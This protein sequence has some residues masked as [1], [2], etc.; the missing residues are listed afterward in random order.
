[1]SIREYS[2]VGAATTLYGVIPCPIS[3][4][5]KTEVDLSWILHRSM[6]AE[7]LSYYQACRPAFRRSA[8]KTKRP[9]ENL[10]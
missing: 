3:N 5:S 6:P 4:S 1:M 2:P 8:R 10:L 7:C 9:G